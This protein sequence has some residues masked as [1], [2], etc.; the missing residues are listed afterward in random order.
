LSFG[1]QFA[2]FLN[3]YNRILGCFLKR[4]TTKHQKLNK[5]P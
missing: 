2:Q 3:I 4:L 1:K 5:T